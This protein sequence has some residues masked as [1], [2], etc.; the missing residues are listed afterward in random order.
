[1]FR[2][3]IALGLALSL[4]ACASVQKL[5]AAGDVHAL[6]ISIRDNDQAT[7][8]QHVDR[9]ALKKV[10]QAKL[11]E[12]V[13]QDKRLQG[14]A[15]LLG[16][17]IVDFAGDALIQPRVFK[18]VAEQ[19]GYTPQTKIPNQVVIA[20]ALKELPD[21]RVCATK[22]K[23]GPCVLIFTKEEGVWKLSGFEGDVSTLRIKL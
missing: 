11:D 14:L 3:L 7:F 17:G 23:G 13:A 2:N 21:G 5:D 15:A 12:Q 22:N 20:S 9:D 16:P 19:Y 6:L 8:E 1:M 10:L 18:T 4:A